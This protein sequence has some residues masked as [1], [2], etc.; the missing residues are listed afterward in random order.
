[1][2]D[3][4]TQQQEE[5]QEVNPKNYMIHFYIAL[6]AF[7]VATI[8]LVLAIVFT[9]SIKNGIGV[10]F[11]ISSMVASL[12]AASFLNAM[13]QRGGVGKLRTVFVIL[14]YI[15]MGVALVIFIA[16]TASNAAAK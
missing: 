5:Q 16:G 11:L 15:V 13:K 10:Y 9:F 2:S 3:N 14:N 1:M 6:G 8:L 12:A 7:I 4:Q